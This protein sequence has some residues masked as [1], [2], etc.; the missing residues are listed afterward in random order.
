VLPVVQIGGVA[1][2]VTFAGV[3][4]PGLYQLNVVVPSTA[5]NGD[6]SLTCSYNGQNTPTGDLIAVQR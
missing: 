2:T 4:S 5:Q 1:A 3:I 6:N